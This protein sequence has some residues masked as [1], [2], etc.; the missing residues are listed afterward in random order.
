LRVLVKS[1]VT[2]VLFASDPKLQAVGVEIA[3]GPQDPRRFRAAAKKEVVI[4]A[5]A[6]N[7]PQL[8]LL[9]GIGPRE[10]L[11]KLDIQVVFDQKWVGENLRDVNLNAAFHLRIHIKY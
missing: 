9:S 1:T 5:G 7:T 2:R 3:L 10:Q 8:L 11:E 4:C 6:I